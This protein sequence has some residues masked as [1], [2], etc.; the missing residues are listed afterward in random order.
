MISMIWVES[1]FQGLSNPTRSY[2]SLSAIKDTHN[3]S[4]LPV[5]WV[6]PHSVCLGKEKGDKISMPVSFSS[7]L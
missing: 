4:L 2:T 6:K 1:P 7:E 5:S 3:N